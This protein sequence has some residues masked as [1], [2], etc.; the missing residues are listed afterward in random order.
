MIMIVVMIAIMMTAAFAGFFQ[1]MAAAFRLPAVFTV[2]AFGVA[3]FSLR[4]V[5]PLFALSVV[6][7][8]PGARLRRNS[9][10]QERENDEKGNEYFGFREHATSSGADTILS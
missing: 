9:P 7:A 4:I 1:F 3:Q 10:A 8:V 5:D 2:F 6:I